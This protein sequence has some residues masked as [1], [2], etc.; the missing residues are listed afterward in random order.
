MPVRPIDEAAAAVAEAGPPSEE[1]AAP[2]LSRRLHS[3]RT[4]ISLLA[5]FA[6]LGVAIWRAPRSPISS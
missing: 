5:T 4:T 3:R 1:L 6:I 2:A